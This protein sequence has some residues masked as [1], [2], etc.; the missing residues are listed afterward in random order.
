MLCL[1]LAGRFSDNGYVYRGAGIIPA[2]IEI[3]P[4]C[5]TPLARNLFAGQVSE[6]WGGGCP[7]TGGDVFVQRGTACQYNAEFGIILVISNEK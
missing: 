2:K 3:R 6:D 7:P 1:Y 5:Q 4:K